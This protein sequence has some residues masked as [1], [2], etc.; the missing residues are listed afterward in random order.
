VALVPEEYGINPEEWTP[1]ELRHTFASLMSQYGDVAV[2][3]IAREMG[4][5]RIATTEGVYMHQ[6]KPRRTAGAKSMDRVV[7]DARKAS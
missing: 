6:L 5:K 4:R 1:Y 7:G 2:E 3:L